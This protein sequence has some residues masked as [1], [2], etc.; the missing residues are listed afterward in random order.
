MK[1]R[2]ILLILTASIFVCSVLLFSACISTNKLAPPSFLGLDENNVISWNEVDLARGYKLSIENDKGEKNEI[3]TENT[4]YSLDTLDEGNYYLRVQAVGNARD[5]KD[6]DWSAAYDFQKGY[7]TGL[8]Y[9]L[10]ENETA[11]AIVNVGR[12]SGEVVIEDTYRND[13]PVIKIGDRAF[14][15]NKKITKVTLG[16]NIVSV[17][18]EAFYSCSSLQE[19]IIPEG[20]T[21]MGEAVFQ[22][23]SALKS[24]KLPSTLST[25]P[26]KAFA[27]CRNMETVE[28]CVD[29]VDPDDENTWSGTTI[30]DDS[31]FVDCRAIKELILPETLTGI[32]S[33]A[34]RQMAELTRVVINDKVSY[35]NS[36]AFNSD[37]KLTDVVISENS[38][39]DFLGNQA[40]GG[41]IALETIYLPEKLDEIASMAFYNCSSLDNIK[42]PDSVT[43]IGVDAFKNTK[44]Y[45]EQTKVAGAPEQTKKNFKFIDRWLVEYVG[46]K[47]TLANFNTRYPNYQPERDGEKG[48]V[49]I[50][51]GC[52]S[53]CEKL[54]SVVIPKS[55]RYLSPYA[56]YNCKELASLSFEDGSDIQVIGAYC[57]MFDTEITSVALPEGLKTIKMYAFAACDKLSKVVIAGSS[58]TAANAIPESVTEIGR[59]VFSGTAIYKNT[60][61]LHN[62]SVVRIGNWAVGY[63]SE[64]SLKTLTID[65]NEGEDSFG[66]YRPAIEH[67][68]DYAFA[69]VGISNVIGTLNLKSIGA[70]AFYKCS[71]LTSSGDSVFQL[72]NAFEEIKPYT[73]YG[74][75]VFQSISINGSEFGSSLK[76]IGAYAFCN[77]GLTTAFGTTPGVI[78]LSVTEV[79]DVTA[80]SFAFTNASEIKLATS[81]GKSTV[82][83]INAY[84]F[85]NMA[86]LETVTVPSSVKT[87]GAFSFFKCEKLSSLTINEGVEYVYQ[88]AF[89]GCESLKSVT[90]PASLVYIGAG[91]FYKC[92]DLQKIEFVTEELPEE[93]GGVKG[94]EMIDSYAFYGDEKLTVLE[95]PAS[96]TYIGK[97]AFFGLDGLTSAV[98]P[99]SI[100]TTGQHL[101]Y[102]LDITFYAEAEKRPD[103]WSARWNSL[104]RPVVW[105]SVLSEDKSYVVSLNVTENTF[106]YADDFRA[107]SAPRRSGYVFVGWS[108]TEDGDIAYDEKSVVKAPVGTVLYA[109]WL[110]AE[111]TVSKAANNISTVIVGAGEVPEEVLFDS[112]VFSVKSGE[113]VE[114]YT[115]EK[116]IGWSYAPGGDIIFL[117][118]EDN[119][120]YKYVAPG[121]TLYAVYGDYSSYNNAV[122][123]YYE[124]HGKSVSGG[125]L[126]D[127]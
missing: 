8:V 89:Y 68:A 65:L 101:F 112:E 55:V 104:M 81:R 78:D 121:T 80:F 97:Y 109:V 51:T 63:N 10:I 46:D 108:L 13:K 71:L 110:E 25:V 24:I 48:I 4:S 52:F 53:G 87:I 76:T 64:K 85:Y 100:Q 30:I 105:G 122:K 83:N 107:L 117:A 70:G 43:I 103:G 123:L 44:E 91:A 23:C 79:T 17:E 72:N 67:I 2:K 126:F 26:Q 113:D 96:L 6:S 59:Y 66:S 125:S 47:K 99:A 118:A 82:E 34:F 16:A 88:R 38:N 62:D 115:G 31:A 124:R 37:A 14:K 98:L 32:E 11:Y 20:V 75:T 5:I 15:N 27:Y 95:L 58:E 36:E 56:F 3:V 111:W 7:T 73:F 18:K 21:S 54:A 127:W 61:L 102:G 35:I 106:E 42:I 45:T 93:E 22:S 9:E 92:Y 12:A 69:G 50:A 19:I 41:C 39:I 57:F 94:V 84:A 33:G 40:F 77:S 1:K 120:W 116:L 90:F 60:L 114:S 29:K 28:F 86:Q 74:C 49:G 119:D